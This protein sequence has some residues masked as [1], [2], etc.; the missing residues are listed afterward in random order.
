ML[1]NVEYISLFEEL[2]DET[3]CLVR[4]GGDKI[5]NLINWDYGHLS[6]N[7]AN[8]LSREVI[9]KLIMKSYKIMRAE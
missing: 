7:G 4:V 6:E 3:S 5:E 2:C 1:S 8:Y 9:G